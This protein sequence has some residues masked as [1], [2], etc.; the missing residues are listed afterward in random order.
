MQNQF[1]RT[2]LL[3]GKENV[4]KLNTKKVAIF[5]LGGVGSYVLEGLARAGVENFLLVDG[6]D[7]SI[8]NLN[9]QILATLKTVGRPKVEVAKERVLEINN[10]AKVE[11]VKEFFMPDSKDFFDNSVDFIVDAIDTVS[12]KIELIVRAKKLN[13][14]IISCMGTGNKLDPT[15]FEVSDI[16]K[17]SVCPLAKVI[18]KEL[19]KR[20]ISNLKVVYSKEEKVNIEENVTDSNNEQKGRKKVPGSISYVPSVAGL[21]IAGEVIKDIL[22]DTR[23]K[24]SK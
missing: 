12:A 18:R 10:R 24:D 23:G 21:I 7:I 17:T 14:P 13:I 1:S 5:G 8:T 6:D 15:R 16:K 3:I 4:K 9:R 20:N 2:S 22:N 19:K 11:V